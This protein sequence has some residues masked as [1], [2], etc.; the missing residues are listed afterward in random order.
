MTDRGRPKI[1]AEHDGARRRSIGDHV[2]VLL[3]MVIR[4]SRTVCTIGGGEGGV[5][6]GVEVVC[7]EDSQVSMGRW[8]DGHGCDDSAGR[9]CEGVC[10]G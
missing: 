3:D 9:H 10:G 7:R 1:R 2:V 4:Y 6:T 5:D 8:V